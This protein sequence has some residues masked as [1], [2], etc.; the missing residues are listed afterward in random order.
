MF[1][2]FTEALC[3]CNLYMDDRSNCFV[4]TSNTDIH[5]MSVAREELFCPFNEVLYALMFYV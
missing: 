5:C 3:Y 1:P 4:L 2:W